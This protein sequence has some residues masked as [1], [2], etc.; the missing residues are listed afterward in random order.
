LVDRNPGRGGPIIGELLSEVAGC[1]Q[2]RPDLAK[3]WSFCLASTRFPQAKAQLTAWREHA[4]FSRRRLTGDLAYNKVTRDTPPR[5]QRWERTEE[6]PRV[7]VDRPFEE[8][9]ARTDLH[10][11]AQVKDTDPF[12]YERDGSEV[13][14]DEN[15]S[16]SDLKL[17]GPK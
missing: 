15:Q 8:H 1:Q 2:T 3:Y 7:R 17:E 13:V 11:S 4:T 6:G 16:D 10:D 9:L 14:R 12:A 5:S